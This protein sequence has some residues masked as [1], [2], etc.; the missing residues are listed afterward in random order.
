LYFSFVGLSRPAADDAF[1]APKW[2]LGTFDVLKIRV[3]RGASLN[4]KVLNIANLFYI[5][6]SFLALDAPQSIL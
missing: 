2:L 6:G 5:C 4:K 1:N 3:L